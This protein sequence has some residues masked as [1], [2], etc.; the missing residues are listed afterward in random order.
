MQGAST[1]G[2]LPRWFVN[3]FC[4]GDGAAEYAE[5]EKGIIDADI[6]PG[7]DGLVILPYF[8]GERS[9]IWGSEC[10]RCI[11]RNDAGTQKGRMFITQFLRQ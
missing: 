10:N 1:A 2:A 8:M 11:F 9:P 7:S 6:P 4:G 5:I 3:N